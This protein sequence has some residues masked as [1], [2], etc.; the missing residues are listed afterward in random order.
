[1]SV[2]FFSCSLTKRV[3]ED[4]ALLMDNLLYE[5]GKK[6]TKEEVSALLY[7][8][9]NSSLPIIGTHLRLQMYNLARQN[10]DSTYHAWLDRH[11]KNEQVLTAILSKKQVNRLGQSFAIA[12]INN[13]LITTGEAPVLY[14]SLRTKKSIL[15]LHNYYFNRGYFDVQIE[16]KLD[17]VGPKLVKNSYMI[18][19]GETYK[20]D[21]IKTRLNNRE[22][23]KIYEQSKQKSV[24]KTNSVYNTQTL[25]NERKRITSNFRD[26]GVFHFQ[27]TFIRYEVDTI[28]D[29][30]HTA[31]IALI[32]DQRTIKEADS[33]TLRQVPFKVFKISDVN[34]FV[35]NISKNKTYA[36][37]SIQY[38]N[39][40]IYS[41]TKLAYKPK[42][43]SD[44]I[45]INKD[46]LFSDNR[47]VLTTRSISN[48]RTFNYPIIE[49]IEDPKDSLGQSLITNIYL[50]S[51]KKM[52][53]NPS[54]DVTHSNI[55]D[56]GIGGSVGL[57][58][59]NVFKGAEILEV[60]VKGSLGS[61]RQM[62]NPNNVFFNVTEYGTDVKL[63]VPRF[64][65][66]F[67]SG[68][69]IPETMLP[70]TTMSLGVSKQRNIG[71]DKDNFNG[72]INYN[73]TP[74]KNNNFSL[75][76]ANIQYI[77]NTNPTNYFHVY[78]S[79]YNQLN[80]I[81][82]KY[83]VNPD[84]YDNKGNLI[85]EN[86]TNGFIHDALN[87]P[88]SFDGNDYKSIKSIEERKVRLSENNLILASNVQFTTSTRT[89]LNDND[90]Y[91]FRTKIETAGALAN[92]IVSQTNPKLGPTGKQT[93]LDLEYSQYI[94]GEV[95]FVKY[96]DLSKKQVFAIRAFGGIAIPYGNSNSIPFTRSY[97]SGGSN[98][99]RGW[100]SYRLGPGRSGGELD[101]NEA[102]MKLFMS[103]EY[104]FNIT[105]KWYGALFVDASNIWNIFD[106]ITDKN[107]TFNGIS[108]LKDIAVSTGLGLRYDFSF[109][110]FRVDLGFKA[111]DPSV[112]S[113]RIWFKEF[114]FKEAVFNVGINYPF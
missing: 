8:Q 103:A 16:T 64:L 48:L 95:D 38:N 28:L 100:Q 51:R 17:S 92:L 87:N 20:L 109:F 31:N 45:F 113:Q 13:F 12:G 80:A 5:N 73:W 89:G 59:R 84:Y 68:K 110:V 83:D 60:G 72:I 114:N 105:G 66:P 44:A 98:D 79:S 41:S 112:Q 56:F 32:V 88:Q 37:D 101:F 47:K 65:F 108:S 22:L 46:A 36:L 102:N 78:E 107:Y 104:R 91:T 70:R 63:T 6:N 50:T 40:N 111:F 74:S 19:T 7:Q 61:S 34:I 27:E 86:G 49:Y 9:P 25:D 14:D 15:R 55:Q 85:I 96:W 24:L 76:I 94:K 58:F 43:I 97:Y 21:T 81:A 29:K 77:K 69:I 54:L 42:A 10:A 93:I 71:L 2:T 99:N 82:H 18:N 53:F 75:D 62:S 23:R 106:D 33:D 67:A 11:P 52:T 39:F 4:R 1:M 90:F 3:P 35:D 30:K 57:M 26:Q